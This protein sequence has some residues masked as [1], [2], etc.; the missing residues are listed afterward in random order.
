MAS[1]KDS[2]N[3][4]A[5]HYSVMIV[6]KWTWSRT[7]HDDC[8]HFFEMFASN[9]HQNEWLQGSPNPSPD[10]LGF[11]ASPSVQANGLSPF[12]RFT[13]F[14]SFYIRFTLTRFY[15]T[16]YNRYWK[17]INSLSFP[18]FY[19]PLFCDNLQQFGSTWITYFSASWDIEILTVQ[20][21]A[22]T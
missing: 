8:C 4:I 14:H 1:P 10:P 12:T 9:I 3:Y 19:S 22:R 18:Q 11:R 2:I 21:H 13:H 16:I 17:V 6:G 15:R 20:F 7:M 5:L